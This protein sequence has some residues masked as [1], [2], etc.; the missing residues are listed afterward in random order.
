M[1][2][3]SGKRGRP[4]KEE[5]SKVS[6]RI[7]FDVT[8][9]EKNEF[10]THYERYLAVCKNTKAT[11]K[12]FF[13]EAI[14]NIETTNAVVSDRFQMLKD[15]AKYKSDFGHIGSN[16]NQV[17]HIVN[18]VGYATTE[19]EIA[20]KLEQMTKYL[21]MVEKKSSQILS[22]MGKFVQK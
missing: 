18:T 21:E 7:S 14:R 6:F 9:T 1:A 2:T 16:I 19:V 8:E 15:L 3:S 4:T 12:D 13:L 5:T 22:L 17:A 20:Q 10:K 11:K